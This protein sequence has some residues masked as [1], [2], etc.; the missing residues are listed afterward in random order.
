MIKNSNHQIILSINFTSDLLEICR[1]NA[2][3][4]ARVVKK[5][6]LSKNKQLITKEILASKTSKK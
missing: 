3:K 5:R 2:K 6:H 4:R 1:N